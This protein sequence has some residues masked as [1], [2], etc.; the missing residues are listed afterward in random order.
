MGSGEGRHASTPKRR[1]FVTRSRA[2]ALG[3]AGGCRSRHRPQR[4]TYSERCC[5]DTQRQHCAATRAERELSGGASHSHPLQHAKHGGGRLLARASGSCHAVDDPWPEID[6]QASEQM[7]DAGSA[8]RDSERSEHRGL[9]Q[10]SPW[11]E[12]SCR[13]LPSF[14][15]SL[16]LFSDRRRRAGEGCKRG[17]FCRL[18]PLNVGMELVH[19]IA[20]PL[21]QPVLAV[22]RPRRAVRHERAGA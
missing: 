1:T 20:R 8:V 9:Y 17:R 16:W 14:G 2:G 6:R 4:A 10:R 13:F 12:R 18:N 21:D 11:G 15:V 22:S 7:G 19:L 5:A 3:G